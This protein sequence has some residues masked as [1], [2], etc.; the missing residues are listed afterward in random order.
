MIHKD[1][2][3]K[4]TQRF[5][6]SALVQIELGDIEWHDENVVLVSFVHAGEASRAYRL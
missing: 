6:Q 1:H 4:V 5:V 2:L 3:F